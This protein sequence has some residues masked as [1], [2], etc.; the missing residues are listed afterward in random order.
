MKKKILFLAVM[1]AAAYSGY[2]QEE[3]SSEVEVE[4]EVEAEAKESKIADDMFVSLMWGRTF[5]FNSDSGTNHHG[6]GFAVQAGNWFTPRFGAQVG[7]SRFFDESNYLTAISADFLWNVSNTF[8]IKERTNFSVILLTGFEA[9][10]NNKTNDNGSIYD[11]KY[12]YPVWNVGGQIKYEINDALD[13]VTDLRA[14]LGYDNY[15]IDNRIGLTNFLS[16]RAGLSY[17]FNEAKKRRQAK[18]DKAAEEE[19]FQ[20]KYEQYIDYKTAALIAAEKAAAEEKEAAERAAAEAAAA[21]EAARKARADRKAADKARREA[22]HKDRMEELGIAEGS[23]LYD[24]WQQ[25]FDDK[26]QV[27]EEYGVEEIIFFKFNSSDISADEIDQLAVI[28]ERINA[29][30]N[31][32]YLIDGYADAAT[33]SAAANEKVSLARAEAVADILVNVLDIDKAQLR[34]I[35]KGGVEI[36]EKDELNRCVMLTLEE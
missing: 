16:V 26:E 5:N 17:K 1:M 29:D 7:F 11:G 15:D 25:I 10:I 35:G 12:S 6:R 8:N 22:K 23:K 3:V 28:A 20:K 14:G 24:V 2:A 9:A 34:V 31:A 30:K 32:I 21:E 33:G 18:A 13:I 19:A 4:A 27:I 36:F